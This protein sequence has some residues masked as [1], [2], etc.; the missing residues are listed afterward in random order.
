MK[1]VDPSIE[2]VACGS[3]S[4]SMPSFGR[5]ESTVLEHTYD[6]IDYISLHTYYG[7]QDNNIKNFLAKNLDMDYFIKSVISTCDYVKTIKRSKKK[8]NL[9]FDEWN[10]W[11]HSNASTPKIDKWSIAPSLLEDVYNFEDSLVVGCMLITLL[12]NADRVKI[13]CLAQLVNVI[14]P[15]MTKNNGAAWAQT[16][17]YPFLHT[18]KYGRGSVLTPVIS[19]DKY[20]SK[21]FTDVPYVECVSVYNKEN[22]EVNVFAVNRSLDESVNINID[23]RDFEDYFLFEH[24]ILQNDDLKATNTEVNSQNVYP[25]YKGVSKTDKGLTDIDL[26]KHS[27][28]VLRF[29]KK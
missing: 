17:F 5:W 26:E 6:Q 20:D 28:N 14:A 19:C 12:K 15:I 21:D 10:V 2:L 13:G 3:S 27:W 11:F 29:S 8:I 16:I 22:E 1:W 9:S 24:I 7:N 23:L 4:I 18:S 25:C